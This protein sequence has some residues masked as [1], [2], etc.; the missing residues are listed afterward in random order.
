MADSVRHAAPAQVA[1]NGDVLETPAPPVPPP[2]FY[3]RPR[4]MIIGAILLLVLAAVGAKYW[5][6]ARAHESTDNAFIEA[7][8][9][10][11]SPKISGYVQDVAVTD[12]QRVKTGDVL[13]QLDS[14]DYT[15]MVEQAR[16]QLRA[17]EVAATAAAEDAR[18]AEEL[19]ARGLIARQERDHA[20]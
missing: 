4:V 10:Q 2:P 19:F 12:N 16:A 14:R 3:R 7:R 17:A 9:V 20:Q 8:V 11:I 5:L 13:V 18:R 15:A 6:F 1:G